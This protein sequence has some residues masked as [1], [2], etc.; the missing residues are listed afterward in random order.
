MSFAYLNG[1]W[2]PVQE[3]RVSILD[4]GFLL[5]DG[6]YEVIPLYQGRLFRLQEHLARLE[7]SLEGARI[8]KPWPRSQWVAIL[9]EL[10]ERGGAEDPAVY[11]QVTRG[12]AL[13]QHPFPRDVKPTVLAMGLPRVKPHHGGR[14]IS[15]VVREDNRWG[16]CDIKAITLLP[17]V[18]LHQQAVDAGAAESILHRAGWL[19]EAAASNV[20]VVHEDRV[21]TPPLGPALL[22]GITRALVLELATRAAIPCA[23]EPVSLEM[24]RQASEVWLTASTMEMAPVVAIDGVAVGEGKPGPVWERLYTLFQDH[25][26]APRPG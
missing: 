14:G 5:G 21:L 10:V 23:E 12:M 13:R 11:L 26:L 6:V 22:A 3:M 1:R 2:D 18:L 15:V 4:R 9:E 24:L 20:F 16:R 17:N 19:T 25:V 8:A 7:R